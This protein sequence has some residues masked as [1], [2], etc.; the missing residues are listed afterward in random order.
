MK[1]LF[2]TV[3][4]LLIVASLVMSAS[5]Y[6]LYVNSDPG[7]VHKRN[8]KDS[9][10]ISRLPFAGAVDVF[11]D[12]GNGWA[13]ISYVNK[14]GQVKTGWIQFK[15]LTAQQP[16]KHS[17]GPWRVVRQPSCDHKGLKERT[18][19]TCGKTQSKEIGKTKHQFGP[20]K[21]TKAATCVQKG[22][23]VRICQVCG[24]HEKKSFLADHDYTP[25]TLTREPSCTQTGERVR[26]CRVC[27]K[28]DHQALD[29]L[30]HSYEWRVLVEPTDHS[31]GT[32][33]KICTV[34]GYDGGEESFDPEGT[35]RR[36]ARGDAVY[37]MQ[38][39]LVELGYLNAG[40]ADGAFGGGTEK[41]LKQFQADEGLTVDGVAWPQTLQRLNHD[42]GPWETVKE[43]TRTEPGERKRVCKDC[44]Y[45]QHEVVESSDGYEI[46]SR[47]EEIRALQQILGAMGYDVGSFDGIYG[48]KLDKAMAKFAEERGV[49][50]VPGK[51]RPAEV[52]ALMN[53]WFETM[54][55]DSW[56]GE[57]DGSAPVN[58]ALT[59]DVVGA[60]DDN[61]IKNYSWTLTNLG[62][63]Q[64]HF[65][66]LLLTFGNRA[67]FKRNNLV[68]VLDGEALKPNAGNSV[69]GTFSADDDWGEGALHFA[70]L[71]VSDQSGA[72][73]LSNEVTFDNSNTPAPKTV[74]PIGAALDVNNLSNAVVPVSFNQ[75]DIA[76]LAS[77]TFINAIHIFSLDTYDVGQIEALR[78]GDTLMV[79]GEAVEIASAVPMPINPEAPDIR[80]MEINGGNEGDGFMMVASPESNGYVVRML[81]DVPTYTE[82]GVTSLMLDAGCV[83]NDSSDLDAGP[84]TVSYDGIA[85]AIR[86]DATGFFVPYN[87]TLT[88]VDNRIT[89]INRE[90]VP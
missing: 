90:Y 17:W 80:E 47:G 1:K 11:E 7:K 40:G 20:W 26:T 85:D 60:S 13:H 57:G 41:A 10:V 25:W 50:F 32:R 46:K 37:S 73:W 54:N 4:A 38:Q 62:G 67:D 22:E 70:A 53:A 39:R 5:A 69:S 55:D 87:T 9:D 6:T 66:A 75:G 19:T 71:A 16:H 81:S 2:T 30:A 58:L 45:E 35:L 8:S 12:D 34:C 21:V 33:A 77:G 49:H 44:G 82:Q 36:K 27:G 3:V 78:P 42:F 61:C 72:K 23:R 63:E 65:L 28:Q 59:L 24:L 88:V 31:S 29:K 86:G 79:G 76:S 15:H 52:D 48:A 18:C 89:E 74:S 68:M 43:M 14:K 51:I 84:V 64:A 56:K 83:Y